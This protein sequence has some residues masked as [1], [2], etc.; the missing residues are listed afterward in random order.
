MAANDKA[1][2]PRPEFPFRLAGEFFALAATGVVF[3]VLYELG[4]LS[5][6]RALTAFAFIL[7]AA[8]IGR[9]LRRRGAEE[10]A[11][12]ESQSSRMG[13]ELRDALIA[14]FPDPVIVLDPA[15]RILALNAQAAAMAPALR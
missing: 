10:I 13:E 2:P 7:I 5:A 1:P 8:W 14:A 15:G 9:L 12:P 4:D 3:A 6:G 11:Q